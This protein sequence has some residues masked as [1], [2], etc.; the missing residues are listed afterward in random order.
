MS[1]LV[2]RMVLRCA[3][4]GVVVLGSCVWVSVASA[5]SDPIRVSF[6]DEGSPPSGVQVNDLCVATPCSDVLS[7]VTIVRAGQVIATSSGGSGD[8]MG[9]GLDTTTFE[10]G[11]IV[12]VYETPI[13]AYGGALGPPQL[14]A[15]VP[16]TATPKPDPYSC[17]AATISGDAGD[18]PTVWFDGFD[19]P[20]NM[21][22]QVTVA[23]GR[24][25]V[26]GPPEMPDFIVGVRTTGDV[27]V[28]MEHIVQCDNSPP[29]NAS[30]PTVPGNP[31]DAS[32]LTATVGDW[33]HE[34]DSYTWQWQRCDASGS[35]CVDIPG[36]TDITYTATADDVGST[37]RIV[38]TASNTYGSSNPVTSPPSA[39]VSA[40]GSPASP[41]G[42]SPGPSG[43]GSPGGP[44][45]SPSSSPNPS[46]GAPTNPT[47]AHPPVARCDVYRVSPKSELAV[48][49][50]GVL[51]NDL[52]NGHGGVTARVDRISF[53]VSSH[54]YRLS[55]SGALSFRA[56]KPGVASLTYHDVAGDGATSTPVTVTIYVQTGPLTAG[57]RAAC[58]HGRTKG[59]GGNGKGKNPKKQGC[60]SYPKRTASF[61]GNVAFLNASEILLATVP[62]DGT[63][64][65]AVHTSCR[66]VIAHE[67][68]DASPGVPSGSGVFMRWRLA[69]SNGQ[70]TVGYCVVNGKQVDGVEIDGSTPDRNQ[71]LQPTGLETQCTNSGLY[72]G[73]I[74]P[75]PSKIYVKKVKFIMDYAQS[76]DTSA[77]FAEAYRV[78]T[79]HVIGHGS[80]S[81]HGGGG[82]GP[83]KF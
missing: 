69:W 36:A 25:T 7:S 33:T 48:T 63:Y 80:S 24:W 8:E 23:N 73:N 21:S 51:A 68:G 61:S 16:Y 77:R 13:D 15:E 62:V 76:V 32:A 41:G 64:A 59:N 74:A 12:D 30:P 37:L 9:A 47:N 35:N 55:R 81:C 26:D 29:V 14:A 20:G 4:V 53:G 49:A 38:E 52:S 82:S 39:V 19:S 46:Q 78:C 72:P 71:N 58:P 40:P 70:Y 44:S 60:D 3:A 66:G 42:G 79:T 22:R 75:G 56:T 67:Y 34:V 2:V 17:D 50:P 27:T 5:A 54:P 45:P 18:Y 11:D 6:D 31:V 57:Q 28:W 1:S 65:D 10:P 43:G 83:T